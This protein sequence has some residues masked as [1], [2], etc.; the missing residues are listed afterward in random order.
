[1]VSGSP[2]S[3]FQ[4]LVGSHGNR[5]PPTSGKTLRNAFRR[6]S[7]P[8]LVPPAGSAW[9]LGIVRNGPCARQIL[10]VGLY[11]V[12]TSP[13]N[14]ANTTAS[15]RLVGISTRAT[16]RETVYPGTSASPTAYAAMQVQAP[17]SYAFVTP[18]ASTLLAGNT[19]PAATVSP[20][21]LGGFL[22]YQ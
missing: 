22:V 4:S 16:W 7:D 1:M 2:R 14:P 19:R 8:R 20:M 6:S 12:T 9:D 17:G 11:P 21:Y 3:L 5:I 13:Y 10:V 18:T 15:T